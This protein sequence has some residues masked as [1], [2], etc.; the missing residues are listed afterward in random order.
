MYKGK[1]DYTVETMTIGEMIKFVVFGTAIV[2]ISG[3]IVLLL[4]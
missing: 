2:T 3:I 4:M 1:H